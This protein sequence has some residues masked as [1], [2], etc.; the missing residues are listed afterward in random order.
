MVIGAVGRLMPEKGFNHLIRSAETL[1]KEGHDIEVWIAGKGDSEED[2]QKMI[3]EL[4]LVIV[5]SCLVF[6]VIWLVFI[7][8]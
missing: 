8:H 7:T 5:L 2:L 1:I 4:G 3:T 6:V